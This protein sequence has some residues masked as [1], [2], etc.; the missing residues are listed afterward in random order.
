MK[1]QVW[2]PKVYAP[3]L[4]SHLVVLL[5]VPAHV[6]SWSYAFVLAILAYTLFLCGRR[7]RLSVAHNHPLW[8][9]LLLALVAQAAA[10]GLLFTDSLV[11][12]QGTLVAFDPTFYFCLNSL[13]LVIAAAYSPI[14]PLYRWASAMD[15]MLAC[16]IAVLFYALLRKVIG[17]SATDASIA[18]FVMWMFDVMALFVAVF[19]TLRFMATQR[20]DERRFYFVL[21]VFAWAEVIFPAA[22]NR[23]ILSSESYVP[24]L[25]LD[26]PFV[27]LGVLLSRRRKVWLRGYRPSRRT[28]VVVGSVSPFVLSLALCLLAFSQFGRSPMVAISALILGIVSYA[29]RMAM[30]LGHH[31]TLQGELKRLQ[32]GLQQAVVRD[33]LTKLI[34]RKG[35]YRAF[36]RDW[37]TATI[38]GAPLTTAMVD[39]DMFK[40]FNDTYGH[41]A[42]DDCLAAVGRALEKEAGLHR[43]VAV[44][45]YG[46]EEFAVL[47]KGLDRAASELVA[48]RLRL[49][50]AALQIQNRRSTHHTVTVSVGLATTT[51]GRYAEMGKL[52]DAADVALYDAKHAGR[53][54]VR[55]FQPGLAELEPGGPSRL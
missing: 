18:N 21:L 31:M 50:V 41:L 14:G 9:S 16:A 43:G 34:N 1:I 37:E 54:C 22:H 39:I 53:N 26:A 10:F 44:A 2:T 42:G 5:L 28:R 23:F 30:M 15:A 8:A 6:L 40:A 17:A 25:C 29:V 48:Q 13:L 20:A 12:P 11:N 52:L 4:V 35:F 55:W 19:V 38:T 51:E 7:L 47:M 24:E 3:L 33:D 49:S 36:K 45:R 46:G 32:R 27:M